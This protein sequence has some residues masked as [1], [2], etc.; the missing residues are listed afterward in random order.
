[1]KKITAPINSE[2][3][4]NLKAGDEA[5]VSGVIYTM[6]DAAHKKIV[7]TLNA[8]KKLP[9]NLKGQIIYYCG[10]TPAKPGKITGACGPTTSSRMDPY[11]PRLLEYGI[12]GMIGKG[13]RSAE[14]K[15]AVVKHGAVYFSALG[16][17]GASY[18]RNIL[19]SE[20]AAFPELGPEAVYKLEVRDFYAVVINDIYGN[21]F[22]ER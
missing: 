19:K 20:T 2:T 8:G 16:G 18:A 22:Y 5:L 7:E 1:L 12:R 17:L 3:T 9:V 14:V 4:E 21:D 10:P 13:E 15:D 6:R 11:T